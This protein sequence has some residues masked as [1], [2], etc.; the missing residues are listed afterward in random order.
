M[1][2]QELRCYERTWI[3]SS[4]VAGGWYAVRRI[5]LSVHAQKRGLSEIRCGASPA[6]LARH[7]AAETR[8]ETRSWNHTP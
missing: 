3:I 6:E 4:A 8:L 5:A 1:T 7:L 2:P